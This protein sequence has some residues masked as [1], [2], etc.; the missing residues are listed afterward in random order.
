MRLK[1]FYH[2]NFRF[3]TTRAAN[4]SARLE[5][6][7]SDVAPKNGTQSFAAAA[8]KINQKMAVVIKNGMN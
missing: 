3:S 7:T 6:L 1:Y 4:V 2:L 8:V 5:S